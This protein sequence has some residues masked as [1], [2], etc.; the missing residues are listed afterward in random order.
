MGQTITWQSIFSTKKKH[1]DITN[2][3]AQTPAIMALGRMFCKDFKGATTIQQSVLQHTTGIR[4]IPLLKNGSM[5]QG[6]AVI[7]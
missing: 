5:N 7:S 2:I 1:L 6:W 3:Q 4:E